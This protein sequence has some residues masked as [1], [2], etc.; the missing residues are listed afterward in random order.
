MISIR[1]ICSKISTFRGILRYF[2]NAV[3]CPYI[4][5]YQHFVEEKVFWDN[6]FLPISPK[7]YLCLLFFCKNSFL[8][9]V[10]KYQHFEENYV[11][12]E[13]I[14]KKLFFAH[15]AE[16][17]TFQ[18]YFLYFC[19]KNGLLSICPQISTFRGKESL[20]F[21]HFQNPFFFCP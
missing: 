2:E 13:I 5:K 19:L 12:F 9:Y 20:F 15:I 4:R 17:I 7:R 21:D 3:F 10:Q 11:I 8:S 6:F 18:G 14:L 16:N 1:S